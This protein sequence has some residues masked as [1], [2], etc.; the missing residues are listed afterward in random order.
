MVLPEHA[1]AWARAAGVAALTPEMFD[2]LQALTEPDLTGV[3][4]VFA[5]HDGAVYQLS[6]SIPVTIQRLR[7]EASVPVGT[8]RVEFVLDGEIVG[9]ADAAPWRVFWPLTPGEYDLRVVAVD[10]AGRRAESMPV[11][12]TVLNPP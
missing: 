6:R 4:V 2:R 12:F 7:L 8:V 11:S 3:P 9:S 10:G 1:M 5:P